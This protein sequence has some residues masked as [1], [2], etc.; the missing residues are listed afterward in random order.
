MKRFQLAVFS[1]ASVLAISAV[2]AATSTDVHPIVDAQS[3]YLLGGSKNGKW[4]SAGETAKSLQ[5]GEK[6]SVYAADARA[7]QTTGS[8]TR[9]NEAPCEDT[10]WVNLKK[11]FNGVLGVSASWN[12]MPRAPRPQNLNQKFYRDEV[13]KV[14]KANKIKNPQVVISQLWR[15]DLDGDKVDEV[16]L[17]ATNYAG[18]K[19]APK[20]VSPNA[21]AG[22]YSLVL[23]RRMVKGKVQTITLVREI[24][25]QNKQFS[26]PN[27]HRIAGVY[28]LN[29]DGK[30]EIVLRGRYYEGDWVS[31]LEAKGDLVKEVFL[32]GCGA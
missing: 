12:V 3:G 19:A 10:H 5:G 7:G 32:A 14:L 20:N 29:G 11:N 16:L 9:T 26:A 25:A 24:Y 31:I 30:M 22:E 2:F 28:D 13:G 15:V 17:S 18:E 1:V 21:K 23:L 4:I 6:Y 27:I 8:R